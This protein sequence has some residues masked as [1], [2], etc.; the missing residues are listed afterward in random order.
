M[1]PDNLP[2]L[3]EV[4][5]GLHQPDLTTFLSPFDPLVSDRGRASQVF[6]FDYQL[7]SYVP[8][9]KRVYGYFCL[10]I[11]HRGQLIGR[12]DAKAWRKE[13][14]MEIK[15]FHPEPNVQLTDQD[16][17]ALRCRMGDFTRWHQLK[18]WRI[19]MQNLPEE[20]ARLRG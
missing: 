8:A 12:M 2:L 14:W 15:A 18:E 1:H 13:K 4:Q 19:T 7:E 17:I 16:I 6:N 10:P 3:E 9:E 20:A 5:Q 11:L